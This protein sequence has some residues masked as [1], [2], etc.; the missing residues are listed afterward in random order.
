MRTY[1]HAQVVSVIRLHEW[2]QACA[3][4]LQSVYRGHLGRGYGFRIIRQ[5]RAALRLQ[6]TYRGH[7][8]RSRLRQS[9]AE[10]YAAVQI[11]RVFQG[12]LSRI[13]F[14]RLV[15]LSRHILP[16]KNIQRVYR[17]HLAR[18]AMRLL[19]EQTQA[20]S[21][22]QSVYRGHLSRRLVRALL[23]GP[24]P[25]EDGREVEVGSDMA[26]RHACITLQRVYRG[27]IT[28]RAVHNMLQNL[29]LDF[30][31]EEMRFAV[32][33]EA[34]I[35]I[36]ALARG[37]SVRKELNVELGDE[38]QKDV[39]HEDN[40]DAPVHLPPRSDSAA[41]AGS[42]RSQRSDA[43]RGSAASRMSRASQVNTCWPKA[44]TIC[45]HIFYNSCMPEKLSFCMMF[46]NLLCGRSCV[47]GMYTC[48]QPAC[49]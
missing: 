49:L 24:E 11:Q 27:H 18:V 48:Q 20:A 35:R 31:S 3:L 42:Q 41:S 4:K 13:L 21:Y 40:Q 23:Q 16:A 36:Q 37:N 25:E 33:T 26:Q 2:E 30:Q 22:L 43:S 29:M 10:E 44:C 32:E 19:A 5:T 9:L 39:A 6:A 46:V 17:G 28:R 1:A 34:A 38:Q 14:W 12:H 7:L 47:P 45:T 15:T 8:D